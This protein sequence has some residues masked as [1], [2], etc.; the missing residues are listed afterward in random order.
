MQ[1]ETGQA[2]HAKT[3]AKPGTVRG[4]CP[5]ILLRRF[6]VYFAPRAKMAS[7][8][9]RSV[10]ATQLGHLVRVRVRTA[11]WGMA[12]VLEQLVRFKWRY[13]ARYR[14]TLW[15]HDGRSLQWMVALSRGQGR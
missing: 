8:P 13:S 3:G 12:D 4:G 14:L 11:R 7:L 5:D 10:R 6:D 1:L 15:I 2:N 9:M